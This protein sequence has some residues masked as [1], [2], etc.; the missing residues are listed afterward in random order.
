MNDM[1]EK[2][3]GLPP[4][5]AS[6]VIRAL[7]VIATVIASLCAVAA[8]IVVGVVVGIGA[9]SGYFSHH[10]NDAELMRIFAQHEAT[11]NRLVAMSDS[12]SAFVR[13]APKFSQPDMPTDRWNR[14]RAVFDTL[15]LGGG[16]SRYTAGDTVFVSLLAWC[17]G[18]VS[19]GSCKGYGF[20]TVPRAPLAPT[21]DDSSA[22][23]R[24][25]HGIAYRAIAPRWYLFYHW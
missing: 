23:L 17:E 2:G 21:L 16:L 9:L 3:A 13:I 6:R 18:F 7:K 8:V 10:A 4:T 22:L 15:H 1:A 11:F 14:Y 24:S 19:A 5:R 12:D 20:S 25:F